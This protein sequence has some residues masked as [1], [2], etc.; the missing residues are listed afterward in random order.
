VAGKKEHE[1]IVS[2]SPH[3]KGEETIGRIMWTVNLALF[4]AFIMALYLHRD[5]YFF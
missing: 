1:L 3:V 2:V 5:M 4:P